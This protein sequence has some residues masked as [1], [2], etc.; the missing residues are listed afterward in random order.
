MEDKSQVNANDDKT[1]ETPLSSGTD[2][3]NQPV[4]SAPRYT[5]RTDLVTQVAAQIRHAALNSHETLSL[6][7]MLNI[8]PI[9]TSYRDKT[10]KRQEIRFLENPGAQMYLLNQLGSL[11]NISSF[12]VA[13]FG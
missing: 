11:L 9:H 10:T 8:T 4:N 5:V 13:D 2:K 1:V 3:K 6:L 7:R 12:G